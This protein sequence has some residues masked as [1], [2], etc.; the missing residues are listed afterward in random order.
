[1]SVASGFSR[2]AMAV[3][4]LWIA[5]RRLPPEGGSH[6]YAENCN[7]SSPL[8]VSVAS[9][10]SRKA[11]AVVSPWIASRILL[12]E[13]GSHT[14]GSLVLHH[15]GLA[16]LDRLRELRHPIGPLRLREPE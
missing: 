2:Q 8:S 14:L 3:A 5:S 12:A 15:T 9:G 10:F 7:S 4:N 16:L 13:A 6:A 11:V 1:M